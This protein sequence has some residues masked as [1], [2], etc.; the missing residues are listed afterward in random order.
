MQQ[1]LASTFEAYRNA[2][3]NMIRLII[4]PD[5]PGWQFAGVTDATTDPN[6]ISPDYPTP[7]PGT[8][9]GIQNIINFAATFDIKTDVMFCAP[10]I[11]STSFFRFS[12]PYT[13]DK[14][15][16]KAWLDALQSNANIGLFELAPEL[17]LNE[18]DVSTN[19][20]T[21][22]WGTAAAHYPIV[23]NHN[24]WITAIWP[25][26]RNLYPNLPA[27]FNINDPN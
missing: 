12:T 13:S 15:W 23:L 4:A 21:I 11:L 26:F 10:L 24:A 14:Q 1:Q 22:K 5:W 27:T 20:P 7:R 9:T 25:W 2:K 17:N 19:P 6:L 3:I 8:I 18:E 16:L